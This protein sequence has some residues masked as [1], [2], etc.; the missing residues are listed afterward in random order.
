MVW[1]KPFIPDTLWS[2]LHNRDSP[3]QNMKQNECTG[4]KIS[5]V[6]PVYNGGRFVADAVESVLE[7]TY[8]NYEIIVVNDGSTDDTEEI[9]KPY[10]DRIVYIKTANSGVSSARNT[11]IMNA[12]G[13]YVAFL[14]QDDVFHPERLKVTVEYLDAHPEAAM[15]YTSAQRMFMDG[16]LLPGKDLPGYS[17]DIFVRLFEKCFIAPSMAVCRRDVLADVGMFSTELSSEGEDYNLFLGISSRYHVGYVPQRLLTY[18][19]HPDNTSKSKEEIAPFRYEQILG[20]YADHLRKNYRMGRWVYRKRMS[21][22][23]REKAKIFLS[24]GN[25]IDA[26]A[27]LKRS[28]WLFPFRFDVFMKFIKESTKRRRDRGIS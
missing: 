23:Y 4:M 24:Q 13:A 15:V 27:S 10:M 21:K 20:A 12:R 17:G 18:R 22:V 2:I 5:V 1:G 25:R 11:G 28:I 9:L 26:L 14:D 8:D 3:R 6:I 16:T 7:Q 19:L